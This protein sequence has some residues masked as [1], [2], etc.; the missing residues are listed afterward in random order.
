[1]EFVFRN[2]NSA[3]TGLV[4]VIHER[5]VPMERL[6]SRNGTVLKFPEPVMVVYER[7]WE[8]VL[9]NTARDCNPF[10][11]LYEALWMLAGRDDVKTLAWFNSRI[12]DYSD[13]GKRFHAAYGC[14]WRRHFGFDQLP[15]IIDE[16]KREATSRRV[17]LQMWDA[18]HDLGV[19]IQTKDKPCNTHA[20]FAI[21][22]EK[23]PHNWAP[24]KLQ[25]KIDQEY[26]MAGLARQDG[27][28]ADSA[29]RLKRI[30]MYRQGYATNQAVLDMTVCNRSND[31]VWGMLG[32]NV[33]HFSFLQ[34]YIAGMVG[35]QVGRYYQFTN[36]L[37][38][39]EENWEPDKWL[40]AIRSPIP[41]SALDYSDTFSHIPLINHR[42]SFDTE[43]E[44][45]VQFNGGLSADWNPTGSCP[46]FLYVFDNRFLR[47]AA[48][49][50]VCAYYWH[51][52]RD[53]EKAHE[54]IDKVVADDWKSAGKQW[55]SKREKDYEAKT[56]SNQG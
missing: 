5:I 26:E 51:K 53:Y 4:S 39:Y 6:P 13:D 32:A 56:S 12:G 40:E 15:H 38:V 47:E 55:I 10:F 20:Y 54:W 42:E 34:E 3:F 19:T 30:E 37:H 29:Q 43:C 17:V 7:P 27:D 28:T 16:L 23:T 50:M 22:E 11:H 21:R 25:R 44:D 33:V 36:N 9:F 18:P 1:M 24:E 48:T 31:M 49:P 2:V 8:R 41:G 46:P 14:R 35:V 45:F 52:R